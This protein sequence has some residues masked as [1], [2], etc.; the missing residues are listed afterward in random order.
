VL[1]ILNRFIRTLR[2]L[3]SNGDSIRHIVDL[4]NNSPHI[5]LGKETPNKMTPSLEEKYI[6][7]KIHKTRSLLEQRHP[8][9]TGDRV[10]IVLK[11]DL[12]DKS[13]SRV[14]TVAYTIDSKE[15]NQYLIRALD[16]SIDKIPYFRLIPCS[17]EIPLAPSI[18]GGKR[19][20]VER[21]IRFIPPNNYRVKYDSVAGE[22]GSKDVIP[23]RNLREGR[24]TKLSTMEREFWNGEA[25][26]N[27]EIPDVIRKWM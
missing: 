23:T 15:G 6:Q 20:M 22:K 16:G 7:Q 11:R 27:T 14:S 26:K 10:R 17:S 12:F 24:P 5:A 18:K 13:R 9:K 19:A 1:G 2:D 3:L 21:I 4:Y 8:Y 25:N